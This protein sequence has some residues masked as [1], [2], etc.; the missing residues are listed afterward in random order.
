MCK[1]QA[2]PGWVF[3]FKKRNGLLSETAEQLNRKF[4]KYIDHKGYEKC[5][6][7]TVCYILYEMPPH[8][9]KNNSLLR[10]GLSFTFL[11]RGH[12]I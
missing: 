7:S 3:K 10:R 12:K 5:Y 6:K 11:M 1:L 2:S 9:G 4:L 8:I